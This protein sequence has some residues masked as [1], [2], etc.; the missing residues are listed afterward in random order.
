[1][2]L[3]VIVAAFALQMGTFVST[4]S[5]TLVS[6]TQSSVSSAQV[7]GEEPG[8]VC[9]EKIYEVSAQNWDSTVPI[10]KEE[11]EN[12][13]LIIT[14]TGEPDLWQVTRGGG[15]VIFVDCIGGM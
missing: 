12:G 5:A 15:D 13:Y 3:K 10:M 1:M 2:L 11:H 14:S 6:S 7:V 9:L 4:Q 8:Q